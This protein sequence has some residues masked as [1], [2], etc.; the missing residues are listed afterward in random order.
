MEKI[1]SIKQ[2]HKNNYA[3]IQKGFFLDVEC[4]MCSSVH[5]FASSTKDEVMN[6]MT[7]SGWRDIDSDIYGVTGFYCG[8]DYMD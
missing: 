7:D 8:C 6:L 3:I 1:Y 2:T 4:C 5:T